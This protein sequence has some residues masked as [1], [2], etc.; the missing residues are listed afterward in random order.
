[1]LRELNF[2]NND[3]FCDF[4]TKRN[5]DENE[6]CDICGEQCFSS[7]CF[8]CQNSIADQLRDYDA[9]DYDYKLY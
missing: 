3:F 6:Y 1:M 2:D 7:P 9:D 4:D 5:T 8:D